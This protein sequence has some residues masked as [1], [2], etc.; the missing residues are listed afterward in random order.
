MKILIWGTS[1]GAAKYHGYFDDADICGYI[2]SFPS[3]DTFE[4]KPLYTPG[5]VSMTDYDFI[6]VGSIKCKEILVICIKE[7]IAL[8]K[9]VFSDCTLRDTNEQW[10]EWLDD[11]MPR[12]CAAIRERRILRVKCAT[13]DKMDKGHIFD[14]RSEDYYERDYFRY[15][16]FEMLADVVIS[17]GLEGSVAELGVFRGDF[18]RLINQKFPDRTMY[19]FDSFQGFEP[20]EAQK[21]LI[22]GNTDEEFIDT[23][24]ETS[25]E[26]VLNRMP[27][28]DK[29]VVR[30]G[31]FPGTAEGLDNLEFCFVSID[32]D[33]EES[34]YQG[35]KWFYPRL[36]EGGYIML[37]DYW[38]LPS[39]QNA[40]HRYEEENSIRL[41]Y[42]PLADN[43]GTLIILK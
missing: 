5:D 38:C 33:F 13:S 10:Y 34:I 1:G 35:I 20:E 37:H 40:I 43:E 42:V 21:E 15:R 6:F 7:D 36:A 3:G 12:L 24:K 31:Y 16:T 2:D 23:F 30:K 11:N 4:G 26:Y 41:H 14:D 32:V 8:D 25:V 29:I 27:H 18:S 39:N 19:L 9:I 17:K 28:K 22:R